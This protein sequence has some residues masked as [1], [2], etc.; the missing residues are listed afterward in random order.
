MEGEFA[1][2]PAVVQ[3]VEDLKNTAGWLLKNM[4]RFNSAQER[5]DVMA[6]LHTRHDALIA[7][8]N[9]LI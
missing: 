9:Q 7:A 4:G 8:C 5:E 2:Y 6:E 1:E 3:A